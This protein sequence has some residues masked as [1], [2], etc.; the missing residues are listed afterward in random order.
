[1]ATDEHQVTILYIPVQTTLA[2]KEIENAEVI[3][4][5]RTD[6]NTTLPGLASEK[7]QHI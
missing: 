7:A 5:V 4:G 2:A 3:H 6:S 1:L